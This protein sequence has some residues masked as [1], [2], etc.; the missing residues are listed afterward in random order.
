M[1]RKNIPNLGIGVGL[2]IPHYKDILEQQPDID[3]FEI[4]SENFM[5]DGGKPLDVLEKILERYPVVQHGVSRPLEAQIRSIL[6]TSKN[7]KNSQRSPKLLGF[8]II[9]A[10]EG[11]LEHTTTIF[12]LYPILRK[13]S[14]MSQNAHTQFRTTQSYPSLWR[15]CLLMQVS[16]KIK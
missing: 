11:F 4:I 13:S 3:W 12:C 8:R 1:N 16:K 14:T 10:G 15:T 7:L 9:S 5:V 2:R 6:I